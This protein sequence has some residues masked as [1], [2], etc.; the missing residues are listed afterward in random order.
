MVGVSHGR[1]G[2]CRVPARCNPSRAQQGCTSDSESAGNTRR[3][4]GAVKGVSAPNSKSPKPL[5]KRFSG[6]LRRR[7]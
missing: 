2:V 7:T 3:P 1:G 5:R 4:A 6:P